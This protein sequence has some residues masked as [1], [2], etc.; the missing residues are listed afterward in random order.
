MRFEVLGGNHAH[1][2]G[3]LYEKGDIVEDTAHLDKIFRC[4]FKRLHEFEQPQAS[5][6]VL[7]KPKSKAKDPADQ[8]KD[9]R[10][11]VV[12]DEFEV[13]SALGLVVCRRGRWHHVYQGDTTTPLNDKGL[14]AELVGP[15]LKAYL[16]E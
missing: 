8:T 16:E 6:A 5:V 14:S 1:H 12:T 2:D 7:E 13:D 15:F 9:A 4:K 11:A 3:K 10:G